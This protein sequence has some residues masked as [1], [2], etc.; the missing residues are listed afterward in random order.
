MRRYP[1]RTLKGIVFVWMGDGEPTPVEQDLPP[2]LFDEQHGPA[3]HDALARQ[4]AA[5]A[6]RT[7]RTPT[8]PTST[9]TRIAWVVRPI[10]KRSFA[11][12]RPVIHGGGVPLTYYRDGQRDS[13]PYQEYFPGVQG[14]WP[15]HRWRLLW[16]AAVRRACGGRT[17]ARAAGPYFEDPEWANGPHMPGMQRI[18]FGGAMYTRWCVPIDRRHHARVLLPRHAPGEPRGSGS[19]EWASYPIVFRWWQYRNFGLQDDRVLSDTAFDRPEYFSEYDVETIGWR[20]LAILA[21]AYGG[22]HDRI[23]AEVIE[24]FNSRALASLHAEPGEMAVTAWRRL[25]P[26]TRRA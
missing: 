22:R 8:P 19:A 17:T 9:A 20:T 2:E 21:A 12:A 6:W 14:Y 4:L 23:P 25:R 3:R 1:T 18:D 15:K 24:K 7:S 10:V 16:T 26:V 11:G 5:G 13:A